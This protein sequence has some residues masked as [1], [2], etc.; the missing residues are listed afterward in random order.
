MQFSATLCILL[1]LPL[2]GYSQQKFNHQAKGGTIG[3]TIIVGNDST[4]VSES[5]TASIAVK[6]GLNLMENKKQGY[7]SSVFIRNVSSVGSTNFTLSELIP[8]TD[9]TEFPNRILF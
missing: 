1:F 5:G 6:K 8:I 3:S 7:L 2:F 9:F 4:T